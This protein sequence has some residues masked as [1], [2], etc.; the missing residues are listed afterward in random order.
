MPRDYPLDCK[1]RIDIMELA[2][3]RLL[4][5]RRNFLSRQLFNSACKM[6]HVNPKVLLE[7]NNA[8]ALLALAKVG[9]GIAILPST[10]KLEN[11]RQKVVPVWHDQKPIG[12]WMSAIWDPRRYL[13]PAGKNFIEEAYQFTRKEFPGQEIPGVA[14]GQP[15]PRRTPLPASARRTSPA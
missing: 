15:G 6:A 9:Q 4:L 5:L 1:D 13:T 12:M 7:S 10:V 2:P 8:Q 14:S 3:Y 11:V